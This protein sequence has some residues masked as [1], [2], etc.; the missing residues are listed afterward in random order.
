MA[1][2]A[3]TIPGATGGVAS[4][5][6]CLI[7]ALGQLCDGSEFYTV[8][9]GS[10]QQASWLEPFLGPN[11]RLVSKSESAKGR[12]NG[13]L[14]PLRPVAR[15]IHKLITRRY[16]PEMLLSDGF[17]ESLGCDVVH[18]TTQGFVL[19]SLPTIYNPHDL[20]HLHYPQ[21]WTPADIAWRETVYPMGCR[22]AHT[23][24][25]GSQWI[26]DDVI[27]QYRIS[28][29]KVQVIPEAPPTQWPPAPAPEFLTAV[30]NKY[31]LK[32]PFALYP[33]VTWPHKNHMRLLEA[34]AYLRDVC[35]L[36][37]HLVCTGGRQDF[38]PRI[39]RRIDELNLG[40]QVKFLGFLPE[41]ELRVVYR[42]SQY[43]VMPSLFEAISLPIFDAWA[44][45]IPVVC[46][47]ATALPEQVQDAAELF[48]PHSVEAMALAM[49]KVATSTELQQKLRE[50]GTQRVKVFHWE[51]TAR[52]YRAV[53]RRAAHFPLTEEDDQLLTWNWLQTPQRN[54]EEHL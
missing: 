34:L 29:D 47:N 9:V 44:E 52:A 41:E 53:Y 45:G 30:Q 25:V 42:L 46:S 8:V 28:P 3:Q 36:T 54:R 24:V 20:Q 43:L 16:W 12:L 48:D 35:G 31:Q 23:V 19:C 38:W 15:R 50:R 14:G 7:H 5:I 4:F 21:F 17:H 40:S 33:A 1:I 39:E 27:R 26:K 18:F 37:M 49:A 32:Q 51:R 2:D 22:L 6:A 11:Q 13:V 10:P